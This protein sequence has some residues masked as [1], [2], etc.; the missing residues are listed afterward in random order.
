MSDAWNAL[1][2]QIEYFSQAFPEAAIAFADAHREEVTP[3][4]VEAIARL[5]DHPDEGVNPDYALHLYAMHILAA[6]R[7]TAAYAPLVRIGHHSEEVVDQLLGGTVTESYG[8]CLASVCDGNLG[9]LQGLVEDEAASYWARNAALDAVMTRVLEGDASRDEL[10][11]YLM[12]LGDA[13]AARLRAGI[14]ARDEPQILDAVISV[15]TD[16]GA[17]EMLERI[18]GWFADELNDPFIIG[19]KNVERK[20]LR[21]P[22]TCRDEMLDRGN[23][24]VHSVKKEIGWWAG[25]RDDKPAQSKSK[26]TPTVVP[27]RQ[28]PKVGRND[29]C[30]C[31]S[32]KKFKKC[33]GA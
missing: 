13:E 31:G 3:H 25:F 19:L 7:E 32:G 14:G 21:P 10:I 20:I 18:R 11:A 4:L 27:V 17:A 22:E 6:W 24:Y 30:P 33:H 23:G 28:G 8:R 9:L 29:P 12:R 5:A 16:I 2:A 1:R 15:A 26:P